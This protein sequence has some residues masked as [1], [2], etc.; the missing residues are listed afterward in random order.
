MVRKQKISAT[1]RRT[2]KGNVVKQLIEQNRAPKDARSCI[3]YEAMDENG[4]C[5]IDADTYSISFKFADIN[6]QI[7]RREEQANIFTRHCEVLNCVTPGQH[8]QIDLIN[9]RMDSDVFREQMFLQ[10]SD[11]ALNEYRHEMNN[12]V[13]EKADEGQNGLLKTKYMTLS[14]H[15]P[16]PQDAVQQL[17]R[18]Q[19][20]F[21]AQLKKI[22]SSTQELSGMDR[23]KLIAA[24]SRPD[25]AFEFDYSWLLT[26]TSV[27][28]KDF[29]AAS[30]YN[31]AP[32][33]DGKVCDDRYTFGK[34]IGKTMYLRGIAPDMQDDLLSLLTDLPF[35]LVLSIHI[36]AVDQYEA[37]ELVKKKIAYMN[38]EKADGMKKAVQ[39]GL[40]PEMGVR[41]EVR[42]SLEQATKLLDDLQNRNQKMFKVAIFVHT[43]A[44]T[45]EELDERIEQICSTVQ[46][47]SCRFERL[48]FRQLQGMNSILPVGPK[49]VDIERTLTTTST[50]IFIPYTTQELFQPGGNYEGLNARSHNLIMFDRKSL[51]SPNGMLFGQPGSGKSM[52]AKRE[53][54]NVLM[55]YPLDDVVVIDP[56]GE[57][58]PMAS[59]FDGEVIDISASS[60]NHINAMDITE[61]YADSDNPVRLKSQFLMSFCE[62]VTGGEGITPQERT[63][64]D[65]AA[66]ATY[67]KFFASNGKSPMP[68]LQE[69]YN[70]LL[71]QGPGAD[72]IATA[73]SIYVDGTLDIFSHATNVDIKKRLVV[74]NIKNL[75]KQLQTL[76]MMVVLDQIWNRV[77][78][79]RQSRRRTWLY[80]D[81]WQLLIS[82]PFCSNYFFEVSGR[83]RKWGAIL[84]TITQ[85]VETVLG[86]ADARR[87]LADCQYVKL[88]N[89][90][91]N[92]RQ[93]L[94]E[95][96]GLSAEEQSYITNAE[97]GCGLLIAGKAI[98]PFIDRF[99]RDTKLYKMMD[100]NPNENKA[101]RR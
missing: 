69:F 10:D 2:K 44:E 23:L 20:D 72:K 27:R 15:A 55:R 22:G 90:H 64:I 73:L 58:S 99:P 53:I 65:R 43:Y 39:S 66:T 74:Y 46:R 19:G 34:Y 80:V 26:E 89:Q 54:A 70:N 68:S 86:N 101:I 82:D 81:E 48:E 85:H 83:S 18:V 47:K 45:N 13:R 96:L 42:E 57:Y 50:A 61:D 84:T 98:I 11:D 94:G 17:H 5:Q 59:S 4:I 9:Q 33:I 31:F 49:W 77:T 51:A 88:L 30:G 100:T 8:L 14:I 93:H 40:T 79:N 52:A 36:D 25:V 1:N 60:P 56:E 28:T 38:Q 91:Q 6:Y 92:D 7:A 24:I 67:V 71:L 97:P 37:I 12:I 21:M 32:Q 35:D 62:L 29:V 75:S 87:M 3:F 41:F 76:G 63:Y 78:K 95:L 16:K